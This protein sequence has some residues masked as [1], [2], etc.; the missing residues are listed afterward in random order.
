V[1]GLKSYDARIYFVFKGGKLVDWMHVQGA[2]HRGAMCDITSNC[3]ANLYTKPLETWLR[4]IGAQK[5]V[6]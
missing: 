5:E 2:S 3:K 6:M 4:I 1:V